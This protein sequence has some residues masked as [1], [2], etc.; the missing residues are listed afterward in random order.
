MKKNIFILFFLGIIS[1]ASCS[2]T[3]KKFEQSA[4]K[5]KLLMEIIQ[6][7]ISRGHYDR[8]SL[9][10]TYSKRVFKGYLQYLDPQKRYFI[11]SDID[12][13]K[14]SETQLDDDLKKMDISF[15][16]LT[17]K[18]LQQ[19][20]EEANKLSV[21]L[22]KG[23]YEFSKNES[24]NLDYEKNP[25]PKNQEALREHWRKLIK[26]SILSNL[27][28]KQKEEQTKK[29]KDSKY[30]VKKEEELK[31]EAIE[32]TAKAFEEMFM[33]YK[34][35]TENDW[36]GIY[37]NSYVE[38]TDPHSSYMA[39]DIKE[40]FDRDMSGKFEGIGAVLQKKSDGIRISD[41][42]MGGPVWKGKLLE[43]GDLILKVGEPNKI[44]VDVIGM[45]LEN[46]VKLIKG[47]KGT[48]V[49]LTVKRVDGTIQVVSIIRDI[50]EIEETFAKSAIIKSKD[51]KYGIINLP[52]FYVNFKDV[53]ERNSASDM[54]LEI[55]K[56]KKENVDGL[57]VDLRNNGGGSLAKVVEIAGLF[58]K[59][60]P[61]VQVRDANG[62][63]QILRD[64]DRGLQWDKPL[65]ILINELSASASEILAAAMQDYGR[66]IILGSKQSYGKGTVQELIDLNREVRNSSLGDLGA[67]KLTRQK[68][69]RINGGSTQL[70]GVNSDIVIPDRYQY[71]KVGE[72]ELENPMPWD[73]IGQ[74]SYNHWTD[75]KKFPQAIEN[76]KKRIQSNKLF[77]L[78]DENARWVQK[79]REENTY[80]LN[81]A[82][83]KKQVEES[84]A[85]TK[86]FK[87]ITEYKSPLEFSSL[88]SEEQKA[89]EN[90]DVKLRRD[91]WHES[92][93]KDIYVEEAVSVLNDLL[94]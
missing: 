26:Y 51:N 49:Q 75:N 29:E 72:R 84:E 94:K 10:D 1:F 40:R 92:L 36:F 68:F 14:K 42:I 59:D 53:R 90:E 82:T 35:L 5:E 11:E 27:I 24:I 78:V 3:D 23:S 83:Y 89:K 62:N 25:Y 69:Y 79:Q 16:N 22:L 64:T 67:I 58:I 43:V 18:R 70:K 31:K 60:G 55:A 48:E 20:I 32:A 4:D 73:E 63:V 15:F 46:A 2:F 7:M 77:K 9:D 54:A 52:T 12:E 65:I 85:M 13:F 19:R 61:V 56:L 91:R 41:I 17:Y 6:Y 34:D 47:K 33:S 66:A 8:Q 45:R 87:E 93:E 50:V 38:A 74:A 86:K 80:S 57:I 71:I 30:I 28:I 44:P 81:Y 88:P 39:P 21:E 76:S 37:L